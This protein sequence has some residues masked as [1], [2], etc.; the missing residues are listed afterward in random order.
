LVS[1]CPFALL[2]P[3]KSFTKITCHHSS[4]RHLHGAIVRS[5]Q[6]LRLSILLLYS[7]S[8]FGRLLGTTVPCRCEDIATAATESWLICTRGVEASLKRTAIIPVLHATHLQQ[9][10]PIFGGMQ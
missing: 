10:G 6:S 2:L 9:K 5:N 8:G 1:L 3:F 7:S 4:F